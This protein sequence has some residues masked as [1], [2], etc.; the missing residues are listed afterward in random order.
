MNLDTILSSFIDK[1]SI[2]VC[3]VDVCVGDTIFWL[4][5]YRKVLKMEISPRSIW[6]VLATRDR[7]DDSRWSSSTFEEQHF[8]ICYKVWMKVR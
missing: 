6:V 4:S 5:E 3:I 7:D 8:D 2:K 1:S